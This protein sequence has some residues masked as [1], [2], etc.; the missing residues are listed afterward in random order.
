VAVRPCA[1]QFDYSLDRANSRTKY[2]VFEALLMQWRRD[3]TDF[4][5]LM[6]GRAAVREHSLDPAFDHS[7]DRANIGL[8]TNFINSAGDVWVKRPHDRRSDEKKRQRSA[9]KATARAKR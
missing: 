3:R 8:K 2:Y 6:R 4:A 5:I 9:G 7:L 1:R